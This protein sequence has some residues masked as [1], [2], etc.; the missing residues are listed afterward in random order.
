MRLP[1]TLA[2]VMTVA[3]RGASTPEQELAAIG[4]VTADGEIT[5][6]GTLIGRRVVL[7]SAHCVPPDTRGVAFEPSGRGGAAD[8]RRPRLPV[9]A[10]RVHPGF[11]L[12]QPRNPRQDLG[13]LVLDRC[14]PI[15]PLPL[16]ARPITGDDLG[17]E[18]EWLGYGAGRRRS[19]RFALTL[20]GKDWLFSD[21]SDGRAI[22]L[23]DSG[24]AV[25]ERRWG[26]GPGLVGV[27]HGSDRE[28]RRGG[29]AMRVATSIDWITSEMTRLDGDC[30]SPG[31]RSR[32]NTSPARD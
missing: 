21:S 27:I 10:G 30:P 28:R 17:T 24:G 15:E 9:A 20:V 19:L 13:L 16:S 31:A 2:L 14:A 3:G 4:A 5:C 7:T 23:R 6:T 29:V 18:L 32:E 12:S 26:R 22:Q 1:M 8:V 11:D 25:I